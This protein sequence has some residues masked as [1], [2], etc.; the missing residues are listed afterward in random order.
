MLLAA[1][2]GLITADEGCNAA[3]DGLVESYSA[4]KFHNSCRCP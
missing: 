1:G 3:G 2:D 4:S